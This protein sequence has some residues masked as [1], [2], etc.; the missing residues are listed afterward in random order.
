MLLFKD[1]IAVGIIELLLVAG[2]LMKWVVSEDI[3]GVKTSQESL[4]S[5]FQLKISSLQVQENFTFCF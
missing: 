4:S 2:V 3:C 1:L 5:S